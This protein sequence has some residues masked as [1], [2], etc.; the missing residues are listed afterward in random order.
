MH[1][2]ALLEDNSIYHFEF[3]EYQRPVRQVVLYVGKAK[4]RMKSGLDTE[5]MKTSF[6]LID[7]REIYAEVLLRSG[8]AGDLALALHTKGGTERLAEIAQRVAALSGLERGRVLAQLPVLSGLRG[9]AD[10]VRIEISGKR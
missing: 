4:M 7:I 5:A 1:L 10:R 8:C 9:L 3:Q 2:L 6:R